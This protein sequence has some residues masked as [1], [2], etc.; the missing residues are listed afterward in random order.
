MNVR[1]HRFHVTVENDKELHECIVCMLDTVISFR[2]LGKFNKLEGER[3]YS[4]GSI[5]FYD[6]KLKV[7]SLT[8]TRINCGSLRRHVINNCSDFVKS[9]KESSLDMGRISLKFFYRTKNRWLF[10]DDM[11]FWEIWDFDVNKVA[12]DRSI[13]E[14]ERKSQLV[15]SVLSIIQKIT[16]VAQQSD[17]VPKIPDSYQIGNIFDTTFTNVQPYLHCF[18]YNKFSDPIENLTS[19]NVTSSMLKIFK[20]SLTFQ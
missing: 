17:I 6:E 5:G 19:R 3:S 8:Y 16:L 12:S 18:D 13:S 1:R 11:V 2:T 9:L 10:S 4:V 7:L 14:V 20:N 15:D